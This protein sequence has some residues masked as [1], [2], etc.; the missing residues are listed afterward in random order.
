MIKRSFSL[1]PVPHTSC[2][3]GFSARN[4]VAASKPKALGMG[5]KSHPQ[6]ALEA[7]TRSQSIHKFTCYAI[8]VCLFVPC[9]ASTTDAALSKEQTYSLFNQANQFFREANSITNDPDQAGRL[10]DKAILNYE[11][12]IGDGQIENPKL[13]YNLGNAHFLNGDIGNAILNY[14]R[15]ERLDK[16][17]TNIQKNLAFARSIR[18]DKVAVKTEKRVLQTLFFWHYDFSVKTKFV[19]ACICFALVCVSLTVMTWRGKAAPW[20]VTAVIC[21]I[22]TTCLLSSVV[23]E[24]RA[25]TGKVCG[26][27]TTES[28]VARQGDGRN[29]PES[30]KD[31]LH[32]GTEFDMLERRPGWLHI[33]LSDNSDGWIPENSA[34]LI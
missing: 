24:T 9:L 3:Y 10:Y 12:I 32:A 18:V 29:Y 15:A 2:S 17:D 8:L 4:W 6:A 23:L 20:V 14:R 31:P 22:L 5:G 19:I 25:R 1:I 16:A 26:V 33:R 11:K 13:Y 27:I 7:A 30:F 34:D 28:I 21:S